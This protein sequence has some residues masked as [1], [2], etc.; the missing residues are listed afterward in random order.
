MSQL[1]N[2]VFKYVFPSILNTEQ[3]K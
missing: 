2:S 1:A 3:L